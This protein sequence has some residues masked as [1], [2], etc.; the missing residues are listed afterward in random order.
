MDKYDGGPITIY[1]HRL[2]AALSQKKFKIV[3]YI[4]IDDYKISSERTRSFISTAN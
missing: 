4:L 3:L 1:P 2:M